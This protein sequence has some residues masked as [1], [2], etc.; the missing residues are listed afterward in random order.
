MKTNR[1]TTGVKDSY[2]N[3]E[4]DFNKVFKDLKSFILGKK[5]FNKDLHEV[6]Y[7]RFTIAHYSMWG[8]I[9]TYNGNWKELANEIYPHSYGDFDTP[10]EQPFNDIRNFLI[11]H[12]DTYVEGYDN[13]E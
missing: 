6:M 2:G 11:E 4:Y 8:W 10:N 12:T 3:S 1:Y 9:H 7:M 13:H 5:K